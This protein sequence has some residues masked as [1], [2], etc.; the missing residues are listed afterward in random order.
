MKKHILLQSLFV[1][2]ALPIAAFAQDST[3][4]GK[5]GDALKNPPATAPA[6]Q[7]EPLRTPK[8]AERD[9]AK[10]PGKSSDAVK[11]ADPSSSQRQFSG[12]ITGISRENNTITVKGGGATGDQTLKIGVDT[13]LKNGDREGTWDDLKTGLKVDG[14]YRGGAHE[15]R[16]ESVNIGG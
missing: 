11:E 3:E 12:Q 5:S 6:R 9:P 7:S 16:A 2:T 1:A 8:E 10:E 15:G 13:K 14:T 4:P